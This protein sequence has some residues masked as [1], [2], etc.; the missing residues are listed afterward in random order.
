MLLEDLGCHSAMVF[1]DPNG[2]LFNLGSAEGVNVLSTNPDVIVKFRQHF[3]L[4]CKRY[5]YRHIQNLFNK[6]YSEAIGKPGSRV[7]YLRGHF[8]VEGLP[9]GVVFKNPFAMGRSNAKLLWRQQMPYRLS[10]KMKLLERKATAAT[11]QKPVHPPLSPYP[12]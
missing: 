6:K 3:H 11:N 5:T 1:V 8:T 4:Q 2:E 10:F 12:L 9:P 7:P